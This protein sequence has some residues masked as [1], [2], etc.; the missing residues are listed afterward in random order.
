MT[1]SLAYP[2]AFAQLLSQNSVIERLE[3]G[4]RNRDIVGLGGV[5]AVQAWSVA[6]SFTLPPFSSLLYVRLWQGASSTIPR[7]RASTSAS[8]TSALQVLRPGS[9][10]SEPRDACLPFP[11]CIRLWQGASS[12]IPRSR[13]STSGATA[14]V[15]QGLRPGPAVRSL[16]LPA[17]NSLLYVRLWQGASGIIPR[18]RMSASGR[19][20]SA[21]QVLRPRRSAALT[22]ALPPCRSLVS[23]V[24]L[25]L[26]ALSTI[27]PSRT[28]T[29]R[30]TASETQVP[31]PES[32]ASGPR[33]ACLQ[34][35]VARQ[36]LAGCL[37][38]NSTVTHIDLRGNNIGDTGA[39]ARVGCLAAS[40]CASAA[41]CCAS[42]IG[43]V[44]AQFHGHTHRPQ[45]QRHRHCRC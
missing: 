16:A 43:G 11:L 39:E 1:T 12:T 23:C 44:L 41:P 14:S 25:W 18:S 10:A 35:P 20:K 22:G 36:A 42:G 34:L 2:Q 6:R 31:R 17:W 4:S 5:Q 29:S 40:L 30:T 33:F 32:A 38:H 13:T 28:S 37:K 19:T 8:I 24:R 15:L 3:L 27:P 45:G 21:L 7:S 9:A 26:G